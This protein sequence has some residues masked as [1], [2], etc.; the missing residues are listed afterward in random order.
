MKGLTNYELGQYRAARGD[1]ERAIT[2]NPRDYS[3]LL[4]LGN[5]SV[6]Q[7]ELVRQRGEG[8]TEQLRVAE[9][10]YR[11]ALKVNPTLEE[12]Q[13]G[14]ERIVEMRAELGVTE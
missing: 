13:N 4:N 5:L 9:I 8:G 7:A 6:T 10:Y 11:R 1:Y 3:S 14:L 2:I 12:A